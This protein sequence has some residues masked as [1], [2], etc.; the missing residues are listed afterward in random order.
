LLIENLDDPVAQLRSLFNLWTFSTAAG[1]LGESA[2]LVTQMLELATATENDELVLMSHSASART[3]FFHAEFAESADSVQQVLTVYD[4]LRHGDL[5]NHYGHDEPAVVSQ[6]VDSWRLWL[7]GYPAQAATR[8]RE[9]CELA[10]RLDTAWG[11]AFAWAWLLVL[12][13]FRGDTAALYRRAGE[14]HRVSAEHGFSAWIAWATF[15]EGWIAGARANEADGILLMERGLDAWRSTGAHIGEPYFL[16]LLSETC[17]RA[18]RMDAAGERLAEAVAQVEKSGERW[19]EAE[20]RP[21]RGLLSPRT[22]GGRPPGG[23]LP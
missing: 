9:A 13:Q 5:P 10:E 6:G 20:R 22:R 2:Q 23:D 8:V 16:C 19:W 4:P 3:C 11:R 18:G 14:M 15:F 17:L 12:L 1:E 7:Q 21:G